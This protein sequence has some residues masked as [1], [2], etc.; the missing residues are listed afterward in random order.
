MIKG[1]PNAENGFR[2]LEFILSH[3]KQQAII[4][5]ETF[6][7]PPTKQGIVE[8]Q[9]LGVP[10]FSSMHVSELIPDSQELLDYISASSDELLDRWNTFSGA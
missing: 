9:K 6:Y 3:P 4:T 10:D 7:G 5:Q 1:A 2:Y 8:A